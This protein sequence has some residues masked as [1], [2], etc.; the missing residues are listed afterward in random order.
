[1]TSTPKKAASRVARAARRARKTRYLT[2]A[3]KA[4]NPWVTKSLFIRRSTA[5]RLDALAEAAG[6]KPARLV[7]AW[8]LTGGTACPATIETNENDEDVYGTLHSLPHLF[9]RNLTPCLAH[10]VLCAADQAYG[11]A[12][13]AD[14]WLTPRAFLSTVIRRG[15]KAPATDPMRLGPDQVREAAEVLA[16][17]RAADLAEMSVRFQCSPLNVLDVMLRLFGDIANGD[18]DAAHERVEILLDAYG[19]VQG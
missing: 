16:E 4:G 12:R 1:M 3:E 7:S 2:N 14:Q 9:K 15:L 11:A 13:Q 5:D 8:V 19:E 6:C 10:D 18:A 17:D